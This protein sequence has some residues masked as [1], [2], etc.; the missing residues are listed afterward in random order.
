MPSRVE[1]ENN[2]KHYT[3]CLDAAI[4][5]ADG[6]LNDCKCGGKRR[7]IVEQT[8]P[9]NQK[10]KRPFTKRFEVEKVHRIYDYKKAEDEGRDPMVFRM[11]DLQSGEIVLWPQYWTKNR[12]GDWAYGGSPPLLSFDDLEYVISKLR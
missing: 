2:P 12:K 5:I 1:C 8:Y 11:R 4:E 7:Y 10:I 6:K 3:R 9:Y